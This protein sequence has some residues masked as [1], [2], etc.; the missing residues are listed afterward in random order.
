MLSNHPKVR[1]TVYLLSILAAVAAPLAAVAWP[2]YGT[3]LVTV[4]SVLA[5]ASGSVA[6]SNVDTTKE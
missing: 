5:A 6:A 4:A 1:L 2:E 3:A